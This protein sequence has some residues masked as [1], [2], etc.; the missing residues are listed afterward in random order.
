ME[1][2]YLTITE[3]F[4]RFQYFNFETSIFEKLFVKS[5]K[6]ENATFSYKTTL[7]EIMQI[8]QGVQ[9][10]RPITKNRVLPVT[11]LFFRKF[12]FSLRTLCKE[13]I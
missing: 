6:I 7:L 8:Q 4:E 12:Y 5:A 9:N 2:S 11:N 1:C 13:L 3:N 10:G